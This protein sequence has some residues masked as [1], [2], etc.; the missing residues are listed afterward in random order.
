MKEENR[1]KREMV[2]GTCPKAEEV[3]KL[4]L[5]NFEQRDLL[6]FHAFPIQAEFALS[7]IKWVKFKGR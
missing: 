2:W 4:Y 6:Y 7:R 3:I 1:F 5:H